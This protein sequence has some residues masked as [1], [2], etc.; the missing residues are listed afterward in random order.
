MRAYTVDSH[1]IQI[2]IIANG[3]GFD[4]TVFPTSNRREAK[5]IILVG[6]TFQLQNAFWLIYNANRDSA[7]QRK[8]VQQKLLCVLYKKEV[9]ENKRTMVSPTLKQVIEYID[10]N[11]MN[12]GCC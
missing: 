8:E 12:Y 1:S 2:D 6:G 4:V 7:E 11:Y 9:A 3:R 5:H 10:E